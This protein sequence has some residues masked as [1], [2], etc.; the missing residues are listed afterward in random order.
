MLCHRVDSSEKPVV[1]ITTSGYNCV[2]GD[3]KNNQYKQDAGV[4][5][6]QKHRQ[7]A[8][9]FEHK[10]CDIDTIIYH[11]HCKRGRQ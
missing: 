11:E 10:L 4:T 9:W 1:K 3:F 7:I 2:K 5:R 8:V 6:T